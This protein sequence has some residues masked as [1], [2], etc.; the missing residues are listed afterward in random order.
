MKVRTPNSITQLLKTVPTAIA[1]RF[2]NHRFGRRCLP[3][4]TAFQNV[5]PVESRPSRA[6]KIPAGLF[7]SMPE[8]ISIKRGPGTRQGRLRRRRQY[9][10][11]TL[12]RTQPAPNPSSYSGMKAKRPQTRRPARGG[13]TSPSRSLC[14]HLCIIFEGRANI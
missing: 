3:F 6:W 11:F 10:D 1:R 12:D 14:T 2:L 9:A 4:Q 5:L 13:I 7:A 8:G